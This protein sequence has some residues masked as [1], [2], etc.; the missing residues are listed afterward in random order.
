MATYR[1]TSTGNMLIA[2]QPFMDA[3]YP[4]DYTRLPD[5]PVIPPVPQTITMVQARQVLQMG[6]YIPSITSIL[7]A[8]ASPQKELAQIEWEYSNA[9]HRQNGLVVDLGIAL[10]FSDAK[11]DALFLAGSTI[12]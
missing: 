2:E 3:Q 1:V 8:M 4:N 10:G 12:L 6:G 9:V 5:D 11:I 7:A